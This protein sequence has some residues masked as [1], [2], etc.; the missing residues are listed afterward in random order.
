VGDEDGDDRGCMPGEFEGSRRAEPPDSQH[1]VVPTLHQQAAARC[2]GLNWPT[3]GRRW[4]GPLRWTV[5]NNPVQRAFVAR[6]RFLPPQSGRC[7]PR[8]WKSTQCRRSAAA[9]QRKHRLRSRAGH[10]RQCRW[11]EPTHAGNIAN[12]N[13]STCPACRPTPGQMTPPG[14]AANA[15]GEL[16]LPDGRVRPRGGRLV[17]PSTNGRNAWEVWSY[18]RLFL[19]GVLSMLSGDR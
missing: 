6:F 1:A 5:A 8:L 13:C 15:S 16:L 19:S 2:K 9:T 4:I 12:T 3:R 17:K 7:R 18:C 11:P 10:R 14:D